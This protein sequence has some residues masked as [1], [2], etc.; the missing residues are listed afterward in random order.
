MTSNASALVVGTVVT[1]MFLAAPIESG[2]LLVA[3]AVVVGGIVAVGVGEFVNKLW[4]EH[5]NVL[6][7][8]GDVGQ[9][10]EHLGDDIG[11]DAGAVG[12]GTSKM[13]HSVFG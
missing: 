4:V 1:V 8:R 6:Q 13:W 10:A 9:A 5:F 2:V 11:H 7:A 3:G 12:H